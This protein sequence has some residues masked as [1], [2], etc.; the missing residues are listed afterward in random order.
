M[1][2]MLGV[3]H[4]RNPISS[5]FEE[6]KLLSQNPRLQSVTAR[7]SVSLTETETAP[8]SL[9]LKLTQPC[10]WLRQHVSNDMVV[11]Y[12]GLEQ[13]LRQGEGVLGQDDGERQQHRL[14]GG[15]AAGASARIEPMHSCR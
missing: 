4:S 5:S 11:P 12:V 9:N 1:C 8:T 6:S 14:A 13:L 15:G 7:L 10:S 2:C 3:W